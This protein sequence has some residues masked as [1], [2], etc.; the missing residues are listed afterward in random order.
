MSQ[1]TTQTVP[2]KTPKPTTKP[3]PVPIDMN[4]NIVLPNFNGSI[5]Q[6]L[7]QVKSQKKIS[8]G[9]GKR[10]TAIR[11]FLTKFWNH[12]GKGYATDI[13]AIGKEVAKE[14]GIK[15]T[16]YT[17]ITRGFVIRLHEKGMKGFYVVSSTGVKEAGMPRQVSVPVGDNLTRTLDIGIDASAPAQ[18]VTVAPAP[19]SAQSA[20]ASALEK[21]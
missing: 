10:D 19:A 7:E 15:F 20:V 21:V 8:A 17:V 12:G 9:T 16:P 14:V 11:Y 5:A 4:Q 3:A 2:A 1:T 18:S 6:L 13:N